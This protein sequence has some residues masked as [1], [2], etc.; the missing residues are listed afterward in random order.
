MLPVNQW[1]NTA[2]NKDER[3]CAIPEQLVARPLAK[4]P[5]LIPLSNH[6][7]QNPS[8]ANQHPQP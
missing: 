1:K 3:Q 5:N 8:H 7:A 4:A 2:T 6:N